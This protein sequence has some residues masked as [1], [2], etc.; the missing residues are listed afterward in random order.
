[1][2]KSLYQT[3]LHFKQH[4][5]PGWQILY[6]LCKLCLN[7]FYPLFARLKTAKGIDENGEIIVSLTSFP[8]RINEVWISIA[9]IMNQTLKPARII[10]WLSMERF[11]DEPKLPASLKRLQKRGLEI[12]YCEDIMPHKKYYFSM[13]ENPDK[14]IVTIDDDIFYPENH[15]EKL[16]EAH[17]KYPKS[18]C[19]WYGHVINYRE[20]GSID[21]Y[22]SWTSDVNDYMEPTFQLVPVG[23]GGVL[24]PPGVMPKQLFH[25]ED[26]KELCVKTDDLW[27]KAMEVIG[28]VKAVRC[29][30]NSMIFFGLIKTRHKGLFAENADLDGNDVA[31]KAILRKYPEVE[32][33]LYE[34]FIGA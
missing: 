15:L 30:E 16:W 29:V 1:M 24:Y 21:L 5:T 14:V 6:K 23:C 31:L 13:L 20:D 25:I 2:I 7:I 34:D 19:C 17:Q 28:D 4:N 32:R 26:I 22:N 33:K 12:R 8:A 18:V 3:T 11:T 9:S 27:L 10:L